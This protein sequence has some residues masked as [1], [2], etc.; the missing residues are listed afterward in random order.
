MYVGVLTYLF[1]G[2]SLWVINFFNG[3]THM[4][5]TIYWR[6]YKLQDEKTGNYDYLSMS[7]SFSKFRNVQQSINLELKWFV[8]RVLCCLINI[9]ASSREQSLLHSWLQAKPSLYKTGWAGFLR[10]NGFGGVVFLILQCVLASWSDLCC[11]WLKL[12]S[13]RFLKHQP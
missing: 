4:W 1:N 8:G 13:P 2:P 7:S 10:W 5:L 9:S 6:W 3:S 12:N 11:A